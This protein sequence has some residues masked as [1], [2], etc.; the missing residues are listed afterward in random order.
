[1][2]GLHTIQEVFRGCCPP[3]R[4]ARQQDP[5]PGS[6]AWAGMSSESTLAPSRPPLGP[7]LSRGHRYSRLRVPEGGRVGRSASS[8]LIKRPGGETGRRKGLKILFHESGVRVQVPPR[9]PDQIHRRKPIAEG[10]CSALGASGQRKIT[11]KWMSTEFAAVLYLNSTELG[12]YIAALRMIRLCFSGANGMVRS[13]RP[14]KWRYYDPQVCLSDT[15]NA[16]SG[17]QQS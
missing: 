9:A 10:Y 6:T 16:H 2:L 4:R 1:M 17:S 7:R 12:N 3:G 15:R 5:L 11:A 8:T 13:K 14:P